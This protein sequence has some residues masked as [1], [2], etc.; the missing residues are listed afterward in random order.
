M[1]ATQGIQSE[2]ESLIKLFF[3]RRTCNLKINWT[4]HNL[5]FHIW[6]VIYNIWKNKLLLKRKKHSSVFVLY[7]RFLRFTFSLSLILHTTMLLAPLTDSTD[8]R[9]CSSVSIPLFEVLP[10]NWLKVND[11]TH[12]KKRFAST[13]S[14]QSLIPP[15]VALYLVKI[16]W[17][18]LIVLI[19]NQ[20][21]IYSLVIYNF[22]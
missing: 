21:L 8:S 15:F 20:T 4:I 11:E 19:S 5:I 1:Q 22:L 2:H 18:N 14:L 13:R 3:H 9:G 6:K 12:V 16:R 7:F 10:K 17:S